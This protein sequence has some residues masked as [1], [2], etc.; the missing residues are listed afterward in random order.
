MEKNLDIFRKEFF[1][2]RTWVQVKDGIPLD[3]LDRLSPAEL[4]I[5][6]AEL[7][8]AA[9]LND[10]WHIIALGHIKS[11]NAL[12]TLYKLLGETKKRFKV[13][14]AHSIF[15]INGDSKMIDIVLNE[16]PKITSEYALIDI[17]YMLPAFRDKNI[18]ELLDSLRFHKKYLVAYNATRALGLSTDEVVK[19][20]SVL[21]KPK[22]FWKKV[23]G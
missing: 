9:N 8:K 12:P 16:M 2:K 3:L 10:D 20:F 4:K 5:A 18:N 23:F 15:Q 13:V 6:E 21:E 1:G 17:I 11:T 7:I 19:K 22:G 14:I